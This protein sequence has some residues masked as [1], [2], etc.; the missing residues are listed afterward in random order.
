MNRTRLR[1]KRIDTIREKY[2]MEYNRCG[3]INF[4]QIID[5]KASTLF[6]QENEFNTEAIEI[7]NQNNQVCISGFHTG[8]ELLFLKPGNNKLLHEINQLQTSDL[9]NLSL[10]HNMEI[11]NNQHQKDESKEIPMEI[12]SIMDTS[13]CRTDGY[14]TKGRNV[15]IKGS[16]I[17]I[18][19]EFND[20]GIFF[21]NKNTKQKIKTLS[22]DIVINDPS[23]LLIFVPQNLEKGEYELV[24]SSR[25]SGTQH[26]LDKTRSVNFDITLTID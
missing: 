23:R 17:R 7:R 25:F 4:T 10:L 21:F 3:A 2:C 24:I 5:E 13:T 18:T 6:R 14:I 12:F 8:S 20:C 1:K 9:L 22:T 11:T 16:C 26:K 15:E 19:T